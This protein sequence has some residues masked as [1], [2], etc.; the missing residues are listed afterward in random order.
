VRRFIANAFAVFALLCA[1]SKDP[2]PVS[3][4]TAVDLA[5]YQLALDQCREQGK[6]AGSYSTYE[7]CAAS[8]DQ[9]FGKKP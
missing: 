8:A 2:A 9:K 7:K 1:C 5:G 4:Q 6:D 3:P